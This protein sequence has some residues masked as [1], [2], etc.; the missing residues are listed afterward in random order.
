MKW[1]GLTGGIASGKS[2]VAQILRSLGLPV[3]DADE[4]ARKVVERG[5]PTLD[6]VA[7]HFGPKVLQGDGTLDRKALATIVFQ[8]ESKLL[9]LESL[10]HPEIQQLKTAERLRLESSGAEVAFYDVP[11]LFEKNLQDEFDA[12]FLVYCDPSQ[13]VKRLMARDGLSEEEAKLRLSRQMPL[14]AKKALA[15][16]IFLNTTDQVELRHQVKKL[17]K[18]LD[19]V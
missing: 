4:L 5:S 17:L 11:L 6:Q 14:D 3:I 18:E 9:E 12:T 13:Q 2:T 8:D 7:K 19:L 1:L 10:L 16:F 15:D